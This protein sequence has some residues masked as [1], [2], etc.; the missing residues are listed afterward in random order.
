MH[1]SPSSSEVT[2]ATCL[3]C[4]EL[5]SHSLVADQLRKKLGTIFR[6]LNY[7]LPLPDLCPLCRHVKRFMFRNDQTYNRNHCAICKNSLISIYS[8]KSEC[9]V[10]CTECFWS[11]KWD[12]LEYGAEFDYSRPFF[13]QFAELKQRTP[14]LAMFNTNSE[15]SLY[16]VHSSRNKDCY[17][18]SSVVECEA[19]SYSDF[20]HF[21]L[22]SSDCFNCEKLELCYQCTFTVQCYGCEYLDHC[23]GLH[24]SMLCI[25]CRG[26]DSLLGCIGLRNARQMILNESVSLEEFKRVRIRLHTDEIFFR[27]FSEKFK[28]L[29]QRSI[30]PAVW[31]TNCENSFGSDLLGC[32]NV[33]ESFNLRRG[34]DVCC[35]FDSYDNRDCLDIS[36]V[37]Y[38]ELLYE[39]TAIVNLRQSLFCNLCYDSSGL[40]YCDNCQND[41]RDSFGCFSIRKAENY[42]LNRRYTPDQY[43]KEVN[44]II[45]HMIETGEWGQ[46]FPP[47]L[48][49]FPYNQSKASDIAP[50]KELDAR[51]L[52]LP[53]GID[54]PGSTSLNAAAPASSIPYS[55]SDFDDTK[56][57][58]VYSCE[59]SGEQYK[60]QD[61]DLAFHRNRGIPLPR[62]SPRQRHRDRLMYL[63]KQKIAMRKCA[64]CECFTESIYLVGNAAKISCPSCYQKVRYCSD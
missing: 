47:E 46:F 14:R 55:V 42:I 27:E 51:R 53:W 23:E 43:L 60:I 39:C 41:T 33:Y 59:I 35:G 31:Q 49:P 5:F 40:I 45:E 25:D 18:G 28:T 16:T 26:G 34:E 20:V 32:K 61:A 3:W 50:R 48:S 56:A 15:N 54:N 38:G 22:S 1:S 13:E 11:D 37:G 10:L 64:I 52:G 7:D 44:Q 36:R 62:R 21:T 6:G 57:G 17:Q 29:Q 4:N 9:P 2:Q 63:P 58:R 19:V 12:P 8:E 30:Y 24:D